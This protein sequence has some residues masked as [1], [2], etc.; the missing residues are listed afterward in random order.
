MDVWVRARLDARE[1]VD[2]IRSVDAR[3]ICDS[4]TRGIVEESAR[5][6]VSVC[7]H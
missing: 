3:E 6:C 1:R 5:L 2:M 7:L 4:L